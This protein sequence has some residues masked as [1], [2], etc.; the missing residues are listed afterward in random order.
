MFN[1]DVIKTLKSVLPITESV[2][3]KY[4]T[5]YLVSAERNFIVKMPISQLDTD[6]FSNI[7][8]NHSLNDFLNLVDLFPDT[9]KITQ[10][11]DVITLKSEDTDATFITDDI[12]LLE[13]YNIDETQIEKT[14]QCDTVASFDLT[15]A[16]IEKFKKASNVL[17]NLT[18]LAFESKDGKINMYLT[19]TSI[20]NSKSNSYSVIKSAQTTKEF[21]LYLMVADFAKIPSTEY[22]VEIKYNA[23]A[24]RSNYRVLMKSKTLE[25]FEIVIGINSIEK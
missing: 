21:N 24:K 10:E 25:N 5:T 19:N 4:P 12:S 11:N 18:D 22:S 8:F 23:N 20:L 17:K 15:V 6:S 16:E 9:V 1:K 7:G 14:K 3:L 13:Q 2:V